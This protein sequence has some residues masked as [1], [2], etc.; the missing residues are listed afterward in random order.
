MPTRRF[1]T[2]ERKIHDNSKLVMTMLLRADDVYSSE[3]ETLT[4][5]LGDERLDV[6]YTN[7]LK[8]KMLRDHKAQEERCVSSTTL[9]PRQDTDAQNDVGAHAFVRHLCTASCTASCYIH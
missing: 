3:L 9:R 1:Q 8:A 5:N 6:F 4:A 2:P 7:K